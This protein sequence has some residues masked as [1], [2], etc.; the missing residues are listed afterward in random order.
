MM[1][2][3]WRKGS[4]RNS[5]Y[6]FHTELKPSPFC[7]D[8]IEAALDDSNVGRYANYLHKLTKHTQFIVIPTDVEPGDRLYGITMRRV[9][10]LCFCRPIAMILMS[11]KKGRVNMGL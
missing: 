3:S 2:L 7:S 8:E 1:Q 4:H 5:S 11:L 6:F 9:Y 10:Q